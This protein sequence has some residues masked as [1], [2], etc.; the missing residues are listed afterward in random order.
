MNPRRRARSRGCRREC[1]GGGDRRRQL[2][3]AWR[4][5][6]DVVVRVEVRERAER[7]RRSRLRLL[8]G[9]SWLCRLDDGTVR[10]P[11]R[12]CRRSRGRTSLEANRRNSWRPLAR[13]LSTQAKWRH[14]DIGPSAIAEGVTWSVWDVHPQLA[15]RRHGPRACPALPTRALTGVTTAPASIGASSRETRSRC[16][17]GTSRVADPL[18]TRSSA[19]SVSRRFPNTGMRFPYE[20]LVARSVAGRRGGR[21]V[22]PPVDRLGRRLPNASRWSPLRRRCARRPTSPWRGKLVV[23]RSAR[24][25][26][27]GTS[28]NHS[29]RATA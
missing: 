25:S 9:A 11:C 8:A 23:S 7:I 10:G 28:S 6:L 20:R 27:S 21:P 29:Q 26:R 18:S 2:T 1:V 13:S 17:T 14:G 24:R 3:T 16:A 4:E 22:A 19:A 15:E 5:R 12:A